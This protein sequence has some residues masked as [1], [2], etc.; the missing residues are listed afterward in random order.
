MSRF[1]TKDCN[2]HFKCQC[3][4]FTQNKWQPNKCSSCFHSK[5][6]HKSAQN[7]NSVL[8]TS[9]KTNIPK[10]IRPK[11]RV[12]TM[13]NKHCKGHVNCKCEGFAPNKWTPNKCA[14][15]FHWKTHHVHVLQ[16]QIPTV[17]AE[18]ISVTAMKTNIDSQNKSRPEVAIGRNTRAVSV[19]AMKHNFETVATDH[20]PPVIVINRGTRSVSVAA[21]KHK[22]FSPDNKKKVERSFK[23]MWQSELMVKK[24]DIC[25][26]VKDNIVTTYECKHNLCKDCMRGYIYSKK[27]KLKIICPAFQCKSLLSQYY[28][29]KSA[30]SNKEF[31]ELYLSTKCLSDHC[32]NTFQMI[33]RSTSK[34]YCNQCGETW[35][36]ACKVPWHEGMDCSQYTPDA[37]AEKDLEAAI[38]AEEQK[39]A[40]HSVLRNCGTKTIGSVSGVPEIRL[41]PECGTLIT[42]TEACKH[43]HCIQC[44]NSFCFVCLALYDVQKGWPCGSYSD[45][46]PIA[47]IQIEKKE[48]SSNVQDYS[49]VKRETRSHSIYKPT[50][51]ASG[52]FPNSNQQRNRG[53]TYSYNQTY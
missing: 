32:N 41:C 22:L 52:R 51:L 36:I 11:P 8:T 50:L 6:N 53:Y 13:K 21:L 20:H 39:S 12:A 19:S 43:M 38:A 47:P 17:D 27:N 37:T 5:G 35:C 40:F 45:V 34:V 28:D 15:C 18:P 1:A 4:G 24:C 14:S 44:E 33:G 7:Q 26:D 30:L 25:L 9:Q 2:G 31:T 29:I 10:R 49:E 46:C 42:H 16:S 3:K 23:G 48:E